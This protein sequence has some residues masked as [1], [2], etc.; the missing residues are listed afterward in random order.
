VNQ[1]VLK[2]SEVIFIGRYL[3]MNDVAIYD[4]GYSFAFFV[5]MGIN[6]SIYPVAIAGLTLLVE[7]GQEKLRAGIP[8][9]YKVLFIHVVPIAAMGM[10][11]GDK[12]V[13]FLYGHRMAPAGNLAQAFFGVHLMLFLT[14]GVTVGAYAVG[15]PWAGFPIILLQAIV[16]LLLDMT[17]IPRFGL[18]GAVAAVLVT[19]ATFTP[20]LLR[21]YAALLGKG[22]VPWAYLIRCCFASAL[23]LVLLPF[24]YA[25]TTGFAL[26]FV[27]SAGAVLYLVGVRLFGLVGP[28]ESRLLR[29]SGL[30]LARLVADVFETKASQSS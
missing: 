3:G 30:P 20:L 15:K 5:L 24:H 27:L 2:Q 23:L 7:Q 25:V 6:Q 13:E 22:L 12:M 16:N 9:L 14:A 8:I 4:V 26:A 19:I 11:Y 29:G 10:M 21:F 18:R 17:L 28:A 1:V